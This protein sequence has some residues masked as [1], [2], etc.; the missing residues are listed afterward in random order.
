MIRVMD[1][2]GCLQIDLEVAIASKMT[3]NKTREHRH[4]G[5]KA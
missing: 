5:K 2:A 1:L 4:G 3:Y